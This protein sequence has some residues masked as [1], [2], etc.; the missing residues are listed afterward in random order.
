MDQTTRASVLF[1]AVVTGAACLYW[2][3]DIVAPFALAIFLWLIMDGFAR[4][5]R[6]FAPRAPFGLA[7]AVAILTVAAGFGAV[8]FV[9]ADTAVDVAARS[10]EYE[11][12]L[13]RFI[14]RALSW[15]PLQSRAVE[16]K[17]T[18]LDRLDPG[19][20]LVNIAGAIQGLASNALFVCIY[21]G[22]LFA[23]QASFPKKMDAL[24]PDYAARERSRQITST[25]RASMEQYLWVQTVVSVITSVLTYI[26]LVVLGLDNALFWAFVIFLFNYVPTIGSIIA[27]FLP[28]L[29]ALVQF[30]E[31]WRVAMVFVGVGFWQFAIGNF[32][33]PRLMGQS[34]NLTTLVVLLGLTIW[35]AIWG[36]IGMFLS[37]PLTVM[38]MIICAQFPSTRWVAVLVSA[39]GRPER[40]LHRGPRPSL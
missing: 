28:G 33:Q 3:R 6:G 34:L 38:L 11:A 30:D 37:T 40:R 31:I 20:L 21:V 12:R 1:I 23:A 19:Q 16:I 10:A 4:A 5:L 32:L 25:I 9:I 26:T 14:E 8:L 17:Q 13:T 7:L 27:T 24:F 39:D 2:L 35:G 29:F 15:G 22:F 18:V 36:L